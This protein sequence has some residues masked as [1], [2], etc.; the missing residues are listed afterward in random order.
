[1]KF[2]DKTHN[3]GRTKRYTMLELTDAAAPR[4]IKALAGRSHLI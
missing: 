1:M 4:A 2:N 3:N